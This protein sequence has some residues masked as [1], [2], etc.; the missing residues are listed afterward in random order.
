M[1]SLWVRASI[2]QCV[3]L[4]KHTMDF[5]HQLAHCFID[6]ATVR[7][8]KGAY[9]PYTYILHSPQ[10][11]HMSFSNP[12]NANSCMRL[13]RKASRGGEAVSLQEVLLNQCI[14]VHCCKPALFK[15]RAFNYFTFLHSE[16]LLV[17]KNLPV[18]HQE[19]VNLTCQ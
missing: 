16:D 12:G 15:L 2:Q 14:S 5:A 9:A 8:S 18:H 10:P 1:S 19:V 11:I 3:N 4:M 7:L 13:T 6:A 17:N